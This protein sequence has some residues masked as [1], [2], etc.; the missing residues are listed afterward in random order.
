MID[1]PETGLL[2]TDYHKRDQWVYEKMIKSNL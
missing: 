2:H 1:E